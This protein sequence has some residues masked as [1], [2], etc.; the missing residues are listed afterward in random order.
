M[1]NILDTYVEMQ[2]MPNIC[3]YMWKNQHKVT[4]GQVSNQISITE[5]F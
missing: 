5:S 4:L 2:L 1:R 3:S